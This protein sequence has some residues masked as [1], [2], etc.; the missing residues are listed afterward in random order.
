MNTVNRISLPGITALALGG[1]IH[2]H[3]AGIGHMTGGHD[4]S[5]SYQGY[6][7]NSVVTIAEVLKT[8]GYFTIHSG[9]WHVGSRNES[10]RP[11][12]RGFDRSYYGQ[13]FYFGSDMKAGH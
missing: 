12:G 2:P 1:S 3:Q 7:N 9:K 11:N 5:E 13:G 6:L 10:M 8:E 4:I